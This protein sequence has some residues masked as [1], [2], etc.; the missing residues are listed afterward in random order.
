MLLGIDFT[1]QNTFGTRHCDGG[2]FGPQCGAGAIDLLLQIRLSGGN[3]SLTLL[4]CG[5]F[6]RLDDLGAAFLGLSNDLSSLTL[7]CVDQLGDFT[8]SSFASLEASFTGGEAV[9]DL[10]LAALPLLLATAAR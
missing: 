8:F 4:A 5:V 2:Y 10:L 1:G 6:G 7:G 9:C 3:Q